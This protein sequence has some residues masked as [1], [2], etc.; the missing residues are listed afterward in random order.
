MSLEWDTYIYRFD[1]NNNN[2]VIYFQV[3]SSYKT[4][5]WFYILIQRNIKILIQNASSYNLLYLKVIFQ[6]KKFLETINYFTDKVYE[7]VW[8]YK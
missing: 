8:N 6:L 4:C 5:M 3:A 7:Y 1:F 2:V